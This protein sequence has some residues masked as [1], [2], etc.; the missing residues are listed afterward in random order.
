M[1]DSSLIVVVCRVSTKFWDSRFQNTHT[2]KQSKMCPKP[3]T[4]VNFLDNVGTN[5]TQTQAKPKP[6]KTQRA[7]QLRD[8]TSQKPPGECREP[9][10]LRARWSHTS[11]LFWDHF[12][13]D[14]GDQI[15][16]NPAQ[17]PPTKDQGNLEIAPAKNPLV[18][19]ENRHTWEHAE[20]AISPCFDMILVPFKETNFWPKNFDQTQA[21]PKQQEN[22]K[23]TRQLRDR[24][25]QKPP[26]ECR[27][28]THLRARWS[29]TSSLFWDHFGTDQGDQIFAQSRPNPAH[30]RAGQVRDRTSQKPSCECREPTH[31]RASWSRNMS[32]FWH[33]FGID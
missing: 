23:R 11:S 18:N 16:L 27:E 9:T 6:A 8:R 1:L 17:I 32:L 28:P 33:H 30:K 4:G 2:S 24:T 3:Y 29:H 20:A 19:A 31:L 15:L 25:S 14:Q 26:G 21:K 7:R 13:T 22:P 12:G 10:C 5:Q